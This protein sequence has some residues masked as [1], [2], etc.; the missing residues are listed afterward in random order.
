[1]N[2][3]EKRLQEFAEDWLEV[4]LLPQ[5]YL[6]DKLAYEYMRKVARETDLNKWAEYYEDCKVIGK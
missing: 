5:K 3:L 2:I 6:I 4:D 1:M